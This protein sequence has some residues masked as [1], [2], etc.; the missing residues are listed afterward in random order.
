M[1]TAGKCRFC[2]CTELEPCT[3]STGDPCIWYDAGRECC[4]NPNC[5]REHER[6][7]RMAK[8]FRPRPRYAGWGYGAIVEDM[9]R[10]AR[11]RRGAARKQ[12]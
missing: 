5:I 1:E 2:G 9:R 10:R 3:L 12:R 7:R 6:E 4:T 8:A 11:A